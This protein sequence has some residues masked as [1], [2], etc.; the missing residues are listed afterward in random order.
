MSDPLEIAI[1]AEESAKAA[2]HRLDR[3]NGSIDRLTSE[4]ARSNATSDQILRKIAH[5]DGFESG[6]QTISRG[7]I[8]SRRFLITTI[9]LVLTSSITALL[10]TWALRGH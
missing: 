4:V 10:V 9:V 7:L 8:D 5:E 6:E 2:H 3:M 1:R